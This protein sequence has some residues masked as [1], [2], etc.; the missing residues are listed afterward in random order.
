MACLLWNNR[1]ESGC[2]DFG[3]LQMIGRDCFA[4]S[5]SWIPRKLFEIYVDRGRTYLY[6]AVLP[7]WFDV[8]IYQNRRW[9]LAEAQPIEIDHQTM[10]KFGA[11]G[12]GEMKMVYLAFDCGQATS[13]TDFWLLDLW[14]RAVIAQPATLELESP[15][16]SGLLSQLVPIAQFL[17][18]YRWAGVLA[19]VALLASSYLALAPNHHPTSKPQLHPTEKIE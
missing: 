1:L 6:C 13:S 5:P 10:I 7:E 3:D 14:E 2:F 18:R 11:A 8:W 12:N 17:E 9:V 4:G 19:I 15:D 16:T